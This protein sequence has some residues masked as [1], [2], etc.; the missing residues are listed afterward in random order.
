MSLK[1][2]LL[3]YQQEGLLIVLCFNYLFYPLHKIKKT[4]YLVLIK[5][6]M[7]EILVV[8]DCFILQHNLNNFLKQLLQKEVQGFFKDS[9]KIYKKKSLMEYLQKD[10]NNFNKEKEIE[11]KKEILLTFLDNIIH[12]KELMIIIHLVKDQTI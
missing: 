4:C 2:T 3:R 8:E 10:N 5:I 11:N 12:H 1:K 7:I 9:Q 6:H